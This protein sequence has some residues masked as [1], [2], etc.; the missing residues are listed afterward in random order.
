MPLR[1]TDHLSGYGR[2]VAAVSDPNRDVSRSTK[3][4][5]SSHHSPTHAYQTCDIW[6][7][8]QS[9][10]DCGFIL[11]HGSDLDVASVIAVANVVLLKEYLTKGYFVYGVNTGFG[12]SADTRTKDLPALQSALLQLTQAGILTDEDSN[13][14]GL[15]IMPVTCVRAAIKG[16][17]PIVPLRG[18][19]SASGDLI[20]L[21]YLAGMLEGNPEIR[22]RTSTSFVLS[23]DKALELTGSEP[24]TLGPK[25]DLGLVNGT[26]PS[27]ALGCLAVHEANKILLLAQGLVAMSCEALLGKA[28]NYHPFI[29]SVCPH[30]GQVECSATTLHFPK[31]SSLVQSL[32]EEDK[33]K[34]VEDVCSVLSQIT[35]EL[36]SASDNP[37]IDIKS[38]QVYSGANFISSSVANGMEKSRLA[39]QMVG[40]L[41]FSL[42]SELIN[43]ILNRGLPPNVVADDP[44]L[45]F[46]TKVIDISMAAYL[47]E[48]G[49]LANPVT[50]HV[51]SAEM[52]NQSI[53]SLALIS[54]RYTLQAADVVAQMCAAHLFAVCQ[55]LDLRVIHMTY[56]K[57]LRTKLVSKVLPFLNGFDDQ[58]AEGIYERLHETI[59]KSWNASACFDLQ[60]RCKILS[61]ETIP[62]LRDHLE[63]HEMHFVSTR[64][65]QRDLENLAYP[66]FTQTR[67][68]F[69]VKP[70]TKQ[71]LGRA[72]LG[73]YCFVREELG[74]HFHQGLVEH[75]GRKASGKVNGRKKRTIGSWVSIIFTALTNDQVWGH[76]VE[77][78]GSRTCQVRLV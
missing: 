55:A 56:L 31:G 72:S 39:L 37:I 34:P 20:P 9:I 4:S 76:L 3:P 24:I 16:M 66:T 19:I 35:V 45:S 77:A 71:F 54:G 15:N 58:V 40:K 42:S 53:N 14:N 8:V 48:P 28:E 29:S 69:F 32:K 73:L 41:L 51:Q 63:E 18:S 64:P 13:G 49:Y 65:L 22:V 10:K 33:F 30:P 68:E 5:E 78:L 1:D 67:S 27:A 23:A 2:H 60:E 75:P 38:G 59:V 50:P 57:A 12:G 6:R 36:N 11:L 44:S 43:P 17:T 7:K 21:S 46:I 62:V 47:S 74:V 26:A 52:H 70:P 61:K 25:E